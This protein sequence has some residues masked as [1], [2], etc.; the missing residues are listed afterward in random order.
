MLGHLQVILVTPSGQQSE[1]IIHEGSTVD[2]S[3]LEF[4]VLLYMEPQ[5]TPLWFVYQ[6][7]D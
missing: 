7:C 6:R 1:A 4:D 5:H 3:L 2:R